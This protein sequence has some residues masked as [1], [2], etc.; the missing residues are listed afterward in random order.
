M[1]KAIEIKY[2]QKEDALN[3][4]VEGYKEQLEQ[5][6]KEKLRAALKEQ[7]ISIKQ[8]REWKRNERHKQAESVMQS[9]DE[10]QRELPT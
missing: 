3:E 6:H 1:K 8:F 7:D 2:K 9:S 10:F 5:E 4:S